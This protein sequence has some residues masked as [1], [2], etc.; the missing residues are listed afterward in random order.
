MARC[1][2]IRSWEQHTKTVYKQMEHRCK[3]ENQVFT[4]KLPPIAASSA[5]TKPSLA[6]TLPSAAPSL[7]ERTSIGLVSSPNALEEEDQAGFEEDLQ[8]VDLEVKVETSQLE[9]VDEVE[10][11]DEDQVATSQE[12][13]D[14][15]LAD[16]ETSDVFERGEGQEQG[17]GEGAANVQAAGDE[18]CHEAQ[19]RRKE[20]SAQ[21]AEMIEDSAQRGEALEHE[22]PKSRGLG[23]RSKPPPCC[24]S[25]HVCTLQI[26]VKSSA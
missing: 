10:E 3:F 26:G 4:L 21:G 14:G 7:Q 6:V 16:E 24:K 2:D 11:E 15:T 5:S 23:P 8:A 1:I 12:Y 20:V 17:S 22:R 19:G 13:D 18:G 25:V 9:V